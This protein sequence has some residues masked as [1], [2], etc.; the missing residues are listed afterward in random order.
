[1]IFQYRNFLEFFYKVFGSTEK[2]PKIFIENHHTSCGE[3]LYRGYGRGDTG[4]KQ[5]GMQG[6]NQEGEDSVTNVI[7]HLYNCTP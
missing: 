1:M 5:E 3:T 4:G 7:Y 6:N 2:F